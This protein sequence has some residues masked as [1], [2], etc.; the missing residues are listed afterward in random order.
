MLVSL[1]SHLLETGKSILLCANSNA[2]IDE[3][4]MLLRFEQ[5]VAAEHLLRI[6]NHKTIPEKL[7]ELLVE[8]K[9]A[10]ELQ[11]N[12]TLEEDKTAKAYMGRAQ[13]LVEQKVMFLCIHA[14]F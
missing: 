6:C 11:Q 5:N 13:T 2:L 1:A 3:L 4:L 12:S 8:S 14:C 9:L 10:T 7:H